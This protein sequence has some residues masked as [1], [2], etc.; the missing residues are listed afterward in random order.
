METWVSG[1][2]FEHDPAKARKADGTYQLQIQQIGA[3]PGVL[4]M[5]VSEDEGSFEAAFLGN[6]SQR[7]SAKPDDAEV[8]TVRRS[9]K[10]W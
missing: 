2:R 9:K 4:Y 10:G 8:E 5:N 7:K 6:R 1:K 3:F